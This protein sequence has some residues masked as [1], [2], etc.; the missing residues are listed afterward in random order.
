MCTCWHCIRVRTKFIQLDTEFW[1][2]ILKYI[3]DESDVYTGCYWI[4][5][6]VVKFI[7]A[8]IEVSAEL[9][10]SL[11]RPIPKLAQG[12]TEDV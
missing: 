6:Q 2:V 7:Q 1:R 4:V 10:C 5:K 11:N 12:D 8:Y 9:Y 3:Q